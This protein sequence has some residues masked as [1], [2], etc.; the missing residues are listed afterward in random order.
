MVEPWFLVMEA[1]N[2]DSSVLEVQ[3]RAV[4]WEFGSRMSQFKTLFGLQTGANRLMTRLVF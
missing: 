2:L 3:P 4:T 1:L